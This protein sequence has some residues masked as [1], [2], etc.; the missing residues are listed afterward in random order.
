MFDLVNYSS[1]SETILD[2]VRVGFEMMKQRNHPLSTQ[3]FNDT[4]TKVNWPFLSSLIKLS[5]NLLGITFFKSVT[6]EILCW[7]VYTQV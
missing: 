5:A 6:Q 7:L 4:Q 3:R 1:C 2:H